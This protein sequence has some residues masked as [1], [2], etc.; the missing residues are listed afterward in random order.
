MTPQER[1]RPELLKSRR[2]G[3]GM[4]LTELADKAHVSRDDL[5]NAEAGR[6]KRPRYHFMVRV[7]SALGFDPDSFFDAAVVDSQ[8]RD[9]SDAPPAA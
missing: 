7:A 9:P 8:H 4:S 5:V 1:F 6:V 2:E 3:K